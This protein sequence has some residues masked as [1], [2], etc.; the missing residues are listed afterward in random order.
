MKIEQIYTGCLAQGAYYIE[1][2]GEVAIIDPLREVESYIKKATQN[3]AKINYIFETHFHADFVSGHVT[4]AEKTGAKIVYGPTAKTTYKSHIATDGEVF[5]IGK[6]TITALHTPGHTMES[7]SYLLKDENG[8]NHAIFSGD[9]LFLGDV[10]R[11]DLAQKGTLTIE[12]LAGFLYDSL[13]TKIMTL[14][15]DV[16]VYPAHG[17]GSAC[18]KNLSKETIGTI[19][20]QKKTNYALRENMTKAEFIKEVTDGLL[21]PPAYFPLNVKMNKEGYE[22]IDDVIKNGAKGLSVA[23]FEKIANTTDAIILDVRHQSEF[24]KGFIPK[25]IFIGLGGTFA[26]WVG[27]LI[28]DVKQPILLVTPEG[29][30]ET[31]ITRLSRV[32]FDNVLGYLEGSFNAWK[33]SGKEI[34]T[35]RSVSADV[36]EDAISKKALVFDARKPGEYAKEHIVDV[37]STPLDFLNDHIEEFPKTEDFYVHCAGGYRSVIAAS[38]LKARGYHN[39]IDVSGGFAAIRKTSIE[40]TVA[41]CPS[42]LK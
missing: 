5:K 4:L 37:P 13:R 24:I 34:D 33:T 1:S 23:N 17:A 42:T 28:K 16:I 15:D 35:L 36:L 21:P 3:T 10:G 25:S 29:E 7:T 31:A 27:A 38:I 14:E 19:G 6:I 30:E 41:V 20:D 11:P 8:K 22:S 39:V 2:E 9:T 18:G 26:P 32:G 40:R 12:D